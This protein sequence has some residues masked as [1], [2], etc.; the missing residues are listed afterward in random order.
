MSG[1]RFCQRSALR[2]T[3]RVIRRRMLK[4][5]TCSSGAA[6]APMSGPRVMVPA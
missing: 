3:G 1:S 5:M 2:M 6:T 4:V